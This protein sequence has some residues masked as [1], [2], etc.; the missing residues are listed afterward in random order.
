MVGKAQKPHGARSELNSVFG[1]ETVDRWNP[2]KTS[3]IQ[4][5][6]RPTRFL[7]LSNHGKKFRSGQR[8]EIRFREVSGALSEV[9]CLPSEVLRKRDRHRTSTKFRLGIM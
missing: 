4:F 3:A 7:G 6:S 1:L 5:R 8:I 2:I 9:H